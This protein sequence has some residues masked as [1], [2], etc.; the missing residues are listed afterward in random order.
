MR[1]VT[2]ITCTVFLT[3]LVG[4]G[5][6]SSTQNAFGSRT[7][8]AYVALGASD[9]VGIG[10]EPLDNGYV[11]VIERRLEEEGYNVDLDNFGIPGVEISEIVSAELPLA[12]TES[13]DLV[14]LFTGAN[15]LIDG[16]DPATFE[17][18]LDELLGKL[19]RDTDA[20]IVVATL[21]DLV[22][23]PRFQDSPSPHVT[24]AR[25][26][27]FNS[28]ISRQASAHGAR[29]ADLFSVLVTPDYVSS[30]GFHPSNRGYE[31]IADVFLDALR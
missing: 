30:D 15:D 10:A 27:A 13:P 6:G 20:T 3:L 11:Y 7:E 5:D 8:I 22:R 21:P 25:V 9:A 28:A 31:A 24:D 1:N 19:E 17:Q 26:T 23:L 16:D 14:T 12:V 2:R 29:V 18:E 4:C